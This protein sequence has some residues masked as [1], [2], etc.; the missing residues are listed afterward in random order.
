MTKRIVEDL[1]HQ[2]QKFFVLERNP[3]SQEAIPQDVIHQDLIPQKL[4]CVIGLQLHVQM[5][6]IVI[7]IDVFFIAT[8]K[9]NHCSQFKTKHSFC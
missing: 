9:L 2:S 3:N 6:K 8:A 7:V 4:K 5:K 1:I